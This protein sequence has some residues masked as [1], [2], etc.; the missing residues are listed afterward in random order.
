MMKATSHLPDRQ[1]VVRRKVAVP[2]RARPLAELRA[3]LK[4]TVERWT[5]DKVPKL[6]AALA[7]YTS[8]AVAP[9]LLI[10]IAV[11]GLLFGAE[12]ARG[13]VARELSGLVGSRIGEGVESLLK[14][15]W[16]P[17]AGILAS[18]L[19]GIAL[20]FG[21]SGV[22]VELQDSLNI[23]WK[24]KKRA[25]RGL[26]GTIRDRFLSFTMVVGIGFLLLVSLVLS[27]GLESVGA[28]LSRQGGGALV[29]LLNP[30][31]SLAV[32]SAL[33]GAAFK[34]LPDAQ[35]RWRDVVLGG[36]LTGAL[37]TL[38]KFLIGV[39]LGRNTI[40]STYGAA[41]S[42]VL[43]LLWIYYSSQIFFLGAEF[44]KAWADTHGAPPRP[45]RGAVPSED[46]PPSGHK[47]S[48]SPES[49]GRRRNLWQIRGVRIWVLATAV[50]LLLPFLLLVSVLLGIH[51]VVRRVVENLGT[52]ALEVPFRVERA[53]ISFLGRARLDRVR[54]SN[55]PDYEEFNALTIR[56]IYARVPLGAAFR[57]EIEIPELRIVRP[58]FTVEFIG[59]GAP[60]NWG[61]LIRNLSDSLPDKNKPVPAETERT[62][63][64][65]T[66]RIV[67]PV[68]KIRAPQLAD[69]ITLHLNDIE[70]KNAGTMPGTASKTYMIL[71]ALLQAILTGGLKEGKDL[72]SSIR[73][74]LEKEL[75]AAVKT[76]GDVLQPER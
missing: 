13:A 43:L 36:L 31:L 76:F 45:E 14:S 12:A 1:R 58:E 24:V 18:V 75:Q 16:Q 29:R 10:A 9:V 67:E 35:T 19:G 38:G 39:Y 50:S 40:G 72:P 33:F 70:L 30:L 6:A 26:W 34:V 73:G 3:V 55:P 74:P 5:E 59:G 51:P 53:R 48:S 60:S 69:P 25:G 56:G 21:A 47:K 65:G 68:V 46:P 28:A 52:T 64:I 4:L 23:I 27:A 8:F 62:F 17:K 32:I 63:R 11:A 49:G 61:R 15:A 22:F 42:F 37:F 66:L 54:V 57:R 44:T 2:K 20:L 71:T 41:G 7:Y